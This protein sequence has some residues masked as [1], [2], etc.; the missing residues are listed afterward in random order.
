MPRYR[1]TLEYDGTPFVG[2][3]VQAAGI[4]V[5]GRLAEAIAKLSGETASVRGAGRT[6]AGVHALGQVAHFDLTRDW[7]PDTVR[8]AVNFHLKP[9]P[10]AVLDCAV[11]ADDFDARFSAVRRHYRYRILARPA[12]PV[13]DRDRVWWVPQKMD[14]TAMGEAAQHLVGRHDFTTFRSASCQAKSPIKTLDRLDVSASGEEMIIAASARSFLHNQVRSMVGS[15][16]L[17]GEGKWTPGDVR[18]ALE[19][20]DRSACGPV[21]PARGLYLVRVDYA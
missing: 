21:A 15:L 3:Q 17:V 13:L 14:A 7:P 19:A 6:D 20:C 10:I 1:I 4:S 12:P 11:V 9:D 5:Q 8:A 16:K 2:W 18:T